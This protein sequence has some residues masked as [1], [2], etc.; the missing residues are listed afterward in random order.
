[1]RPYYALAVIALLGRMRKRTGA[2]DGEHAGDS[3][4]C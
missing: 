2:Q 4:A 3:D 1:M